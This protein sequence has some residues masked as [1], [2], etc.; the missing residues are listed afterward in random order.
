MTILNAFA[1]YDID[2][3][4]KGRTIEIG[5]GGLYWGPTGLVG[6]GVVKAKTKRIDLPLY[7]KEPRWVERA[8]TELLLRSAQR[9]D[10]YPLCVIRD[11]ERDHGIYMPS[12]TGLAYNEVLVV[13]ADPGDVGG[14]VIARGSR[15]VYGLFTHKLKKGTVVVYELEMKNRFERQEVV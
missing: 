12:Q 15:D 5:C 11:V 13:R 7:L 8:A 2:C 14:W 1:D 3:E 10:G 9:F 6:A 4:V